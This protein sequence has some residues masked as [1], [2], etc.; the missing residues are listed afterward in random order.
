MGGHIRARRIVFWAV[1]AAATVVVVASIVETFTADPHEG[2]GWIGGPIQLVFAGGPLIAVAIG[3]RSQRQ[4]VA[5]KTAIGSLVLALVVGFVLVMQL[6]DPNETTGDRVL[7]GL[8]VVVYLAAFV[9]ELPAFTSHWP[10]SH[11]PALG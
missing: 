9:V 5:K 1:V 6:L 2:E 7:Q 3:L 8:A 11:T 10:S 4:S